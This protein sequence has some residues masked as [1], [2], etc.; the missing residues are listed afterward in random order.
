MKA[1]VLAAGEGKRM[2]PLTYERPKVMLPIAGKPIIERLLGVVK[3][4][5]IDDLVLVVGYHDETIRNYFGEGE[6]WGINIEYV[7]QKMQ[8]GTADALR[9]AEGLVEDKFVLLNG[10]TIVYA[11]DIRR[12]MTDSITLGV[13]EVRNPEDYGVVETEGEKIIR[14]HEKMKHPITNLINAGLYFLDERIIE[15]LQKTE[16][17]ER[18]EFEL[19]DS[20]QLLIESGED[21]FWKRIERWIDVSYPWDLLTA[22]ESLIDKISPVNRGVVE[23]NSR[24]KG[25][26]SIGEG[27]VIRSGTYIEGPIFIGNN[28]E[29]GPNSYIRANTAIGDNCHIGNAVEIKNSIIM[30]RTKIPH[31]SYVGDSVI[32]SRCNLGAG[33]MIANLRFDNETVKVKGVTD[34]R[35][36]DTRR[37]K[38]GVIMGDGVKTGINASIY[39]GSVIGNDTYIGPIAYALGYI[40]RNSRIY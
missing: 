29:I 10:D 33:T 12:V 28:C 17:S 14:I 13:V 23:E 38:F 15:V 25:K 39:A 8:L 18:G 24:I 26:V 6:R 21:I 2:R 5:G 22:N 40:E 4:A 9:R 32:G 37:R 3:E 11:E 16:R 27:T 20:L 7:T 35:S 30:D 19:T 31:L 1:V 34:T 36:V